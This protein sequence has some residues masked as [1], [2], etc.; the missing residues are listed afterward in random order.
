MKYTEEF[1]HESF[2]WLYNIRGPR[3]I[4]RLRRL[5][6]QHGPEEAMRRVKHPTMSDEL[7]ECHA[8]AIQHVAN[9]LTPLTG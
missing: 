5:V 9:Q 3:F 4:R 7:V 2:V 1:R 8:A 6:D